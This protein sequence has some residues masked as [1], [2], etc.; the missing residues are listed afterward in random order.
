MDITTATPAPEPS[1][2]ADR[3]AALERFARTCGVTEE[4]LADAEALTWLAEQASL[5]LERKWAAEEWEARARSL[6][7]LLAILRAE[8][9]GNYFD[10]TKA[11]S[12]IEAALYLQEEDE[13]SDA[14]YET[15]TE[16]GD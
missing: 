7:A 14:V 2:P 1:L 4:G 9:V 8:L 5:A 15:T 11:L 13:D 6:E 16:N 3:L 12:R 10:Q